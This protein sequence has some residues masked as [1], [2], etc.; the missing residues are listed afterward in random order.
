MQGIPEERVQADVSIKA[1]TPFLSSREAY[2]Y[3]SSVEPSGCVMCIGVNTYTEM[4]S[5]C[6]DFIDGRTFKMSDLDL[7]FVATNAGSKANPRNPDRQL[8]RY[9]LMEVLVRLSMDKFYKS[10]LLFHI[11]INSWSMQ[12]I[13]RCPQNSLRSAFL[14]LLLPV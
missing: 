5:S 13:P 8:V 1:L 3:F 9:Q 11:C 14:T 2:K 7:E 12:D 4:I 10:K 6:G